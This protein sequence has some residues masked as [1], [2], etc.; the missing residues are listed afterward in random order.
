M[1]SK[2]VFSEGEGPPRRFGLLTGQ[3]NAD[4]VRPWDLARVPEA[5]NAGFELEVI[6]H[7]VVSEASRWPIEAAQ[8]TAT[9]SN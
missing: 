1:I 3:G 9:G 4:R 7:D 2:R 6:S 5:L 8:G